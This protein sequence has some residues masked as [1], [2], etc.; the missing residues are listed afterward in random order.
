MD[1]YQLANGVITANDGRTSIPVDE[2]N[3]DYRTYL[4]DTGKIHEDVLAEVA[5]AEVV[6]AA[7]DDKIRAD[8]TKAARS[9]IRKLIALGLTRPELRALGII[10]PDPDN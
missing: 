8:R 1:D 3:T 4:A 6:L 2:A 9:G 10:D 5:A 7:A